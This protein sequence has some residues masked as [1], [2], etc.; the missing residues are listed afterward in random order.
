M[1]AEEAGVVLFETPRLIVR[2]VTPDDVAALLTIFGD[3]ENVRHYGTGL[4]WSRLEVEQFI[5]SYPSGDA[6]LVSA[7][8]LALLKPGLDVVG[9]GGVGYYL[10]EGNTADLLFAFKCDH[11]GKGLATELAQA[12]IATAFR[13][14]EVA[15]V[16][17]T[18]KPAN[19]A[20][21]RVLEKCGMRLQRYLP[22][23]DR[24]LFTLSKEAWQ[25]SEWIAPGA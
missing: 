8:G 12:A 4:P 5:A 1:H 25:S 22:D 9:F 20:S 16:H 19:P 18:A 7:P 10:W 24:L 17:A 6:R 2:Q 11:W 21:V 15:V 14:P 3:A 13:Q 23:A